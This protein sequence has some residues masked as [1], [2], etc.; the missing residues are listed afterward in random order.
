MLEERPTPHHIYYRCIYFPVDEANSQFVWLKHLRGDNDHQL[1]I[2][3][4]DV[5]TYI[6]GKP[7]N[8]EHAL[9]APP[10]DWAPI[11]Q[12]NQRAALQQLSRQQ[13]APERVL[14]QAAR[15]GW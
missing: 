9:L 12:H 8:G 13:A 14:A 11:Q 10:R 3:R 6:L 4:N 15:Q 7:S 5:K 2:D 1:I